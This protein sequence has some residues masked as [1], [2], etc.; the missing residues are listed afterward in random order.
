MI[1]SAIFMFLAAF[2][3]GKMQVFIFLSLAFGIIDLMLPSA[4]ALCIDLGKKYSGAVSGAMNTAGNLGGFVCS[5]I[6]GYVVSATGNYNL[7]L[8]IIAGMLVISAVIFLF[9][10]P[11]KQLIKDE[12]NLS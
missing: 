5:L 12:E 4:W 6:F 11:T 1:I 10:D 8:Y 3:P 9:I 7:P 2:I